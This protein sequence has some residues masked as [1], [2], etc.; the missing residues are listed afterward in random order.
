MG[1]AL[2]ILVVEDDPAIA[3]L[4]TY[5]LEQAGF[6]VVLASSGEEGLRRAEQEQPALAILDWMLPVVSGLSACRQLRQRETT[7]SLPIILLTARGQEQDRVQGLETG[8]DDYIVKPFS[9]AE[10][11]ARV[12]ALLRRLGRQ[13]EK[14]PYLSYAGLVMDTTTHTVE[15]EGVPLHLAPT[16]FRLLKHF[17]QHPTHVFSREQLLDAVWGN[18][19]HVEDRTV[20]V[21]IRRLRRALNGEGRFPD[22][23]RTVRTAGYSLCR[24]EE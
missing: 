21:H 9:P 16:E 14:S 2:R 24:G 22:L 17:L 10:L 20:D 12:N 4:L 7:R 8:A 19:I 13:L 5:T 18:G 3:T 6:Q 23:I 15:R 11:V 1:K